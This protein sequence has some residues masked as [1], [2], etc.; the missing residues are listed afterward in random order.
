MKEF[1]KQAEIEKEYA[2]WKE[3]R[4]ITSCNKLQTETNA[5]WKK[6]FYELEGRKLV[7]EE[8]LYNHTI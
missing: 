5:T 8:R 1:I 2:Q 4:V 3:V 7:N 6:A